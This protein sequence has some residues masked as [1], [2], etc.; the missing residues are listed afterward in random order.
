[1]WCFGETAFQMLTGHASFEN[2]ADLYKFQDDAAQFPSQALRLVNAS[3]EAIHFIRSLMLP[4]PSGRLNAD[5]AGQHPWLRIDDEPVIAPPTTSTWTQPG[6]GLGGLA[7]GGGPSPWSFISQT[8]NQLTQASGQWSA[9]ITR[10]NPVDGAFVYLGVSPEQEPLQP[11]SNFAARSDLTLASGSQN[12]ATQYWDRHRLSEM[13]LELPKEQRSSMEMVDPPFRR[14]SYQPPRDSPPLSTEGLDATGR[15]TAEPR[16]GTEITARDDMA[17]GLGYVSSI[18]L[19]EAPPA[20]NTR[21]SHPVIVNGT[22]QPPPP[23]LLPQ[24]YRSRREMDYHN[25]SEAPSV[26]PTN[27]SLSPKSLGFEHLHNRNYSLVSLETAPGCG[28]D[29]ATEEEIARATGEQVAKDPAA[30]QIDE[31]ERMIFEMEER[32]AK[33]E[34][35]RAVA[36]SAS[37]K[38]K[39]SRR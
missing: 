23:R 18:P 36:M 24:T 35:E 16:A 34:L 13:S 15:V 7:Y 11:S 31:L 10:R 8:D 22:K 37:V 5:Q 21:R 30:G 17:R 38:R 27:R 2:L 28:E 9:T 39:R 32:A 19:P 3:E 14:H 26:I 20:R 1:M 4:V 29:V 6:P 12:T 33:R 25:G